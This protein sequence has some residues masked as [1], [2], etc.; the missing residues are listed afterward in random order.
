M[1][2]RPVVAWSDVE[3]VLDRLSD[4]HR[5]EYAK[6]GWPSTE[7]M[8][9]MA[10]FMSLAR[11]ECLWFDDAPQAVLAIKRGDP[12]PC[13]WLAVTREFFQRPAATKFARRYMADA[14][15]TFGPILSVVGSG[16]PD[17]AKWMRVLGAKQIDKNIFL[18]S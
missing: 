2:A 14:V 7:F 3:N 12:L 15:R 16:H 11:T 8:A 10:R 1:E 17:A 5:E 4:Q 6:A 18:F 9:R 13:T